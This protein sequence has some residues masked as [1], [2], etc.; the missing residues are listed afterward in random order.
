M[1]ISNSVIHLQVEILL[2][3]FSQMLR[4]VNSASSIFAKLKK[5]I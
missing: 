1:Y 2:F 3:D 5:M 4:A